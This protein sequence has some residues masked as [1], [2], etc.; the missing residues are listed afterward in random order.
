MH[1]RYAVRPD[2]DR[3][4]RAPVSTRCA[5]AAV[6]SGALLAACGGDDV[7]SPTAAQP[8]QTNTPAPAPS[9]APADA[10][11]PIASRPVWRCATAC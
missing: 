11:A 4:G 2:G 3:A 5:L 1:D 9:A 6:L 10:P 7:G 8:T